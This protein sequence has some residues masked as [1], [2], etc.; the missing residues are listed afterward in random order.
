MALKYWDE[1]KAAGGFHQSLFEAHVMP[2]E[3]AGNPEMS[4][5]AYRSLEVFT[6][7]IHTPRQRR[8]HSQDPIPRFF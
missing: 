2:F 7:V 4:I 1:T 8:R 3:N 6:E 5:P